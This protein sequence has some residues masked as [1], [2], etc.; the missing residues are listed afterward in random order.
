[1]KARCFFAPVPMQGFVRRYKRFR[2]AKKGFVYMEKMT[3]IRKAMWHFLG[4]KQ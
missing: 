1:M 3:M 4:A 2:P